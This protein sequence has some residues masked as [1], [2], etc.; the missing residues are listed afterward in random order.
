MRRIVNILTLILF[1]SAAHYA[2]ASAAGEKRLDDIVEW[3]GAKKTL[4]VDYSASSKGESI[5]GKMVLAGERFKIESAVMDT[6]F[7]GKTQWTYNPS[8][9]EV[10]IT[11]PTDEEILQVNPLAIINAFKSG[12]NVNIGQSERQDPRFDLLVLT[13]KNDDADIK[14]VEI[15]VAKG[16]NNPSRIILRMADGSTLVLNLR[17]FVR[18]GTFR[19]SDFTFMPSLHPDAQVIDLR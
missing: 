13:P 12:Y 11:E 1:F 8:T 4:E 17:K 18:G 15:S 6:W 7:D 19:V 3:L 5:S 9:N 10:S 14:R 2:H 16:V